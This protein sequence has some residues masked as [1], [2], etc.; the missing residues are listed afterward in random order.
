MNELLIEIGTEE[1]PA[2]PLLKEL[3]NIE[4]KW[5][6]ILE[7]YHLKSDFKFYYTP[8]RLVFFHENFPNKQ[9]DTFAQF[10]GAP[11]NIAYKD[12][13]LTPAGES[14][15]QKAQI[16]ENEL[17]FK[18]IKGKEVLYHQ[19]TIRGLSSQEILAPMINEFLKNLHFGKSMRWGAHTFEFIRAIRSIVCIFNDNLIDFESYGVKSAKKT[20]IHRS[21][22]YDLQEFNTIE[23]YFKLL[24]KNFIILDPLKRKERILKQFKTLEEQN[25]I[26]IAQDEELLAEVIAITEYPNALLGS[27][28]KTYLQIPHEVIIHSMRENQ[29]YFA[30]FNEKKLS[31]HFIVVSNAVCKDYSK[32]IH[33]NERVLHAR[34]SD[35]M[36]FYKNDIQNG[37]IP[38]KLNQI[39]YLEGLGTM[40]DKSLREIKI[41]EILCQML[42]NDQIANISTAIKYSKADLTTQ[43]VYEFTSLQGIMGSYYAQKMGLD[44]TICLAIK[45]QYLP[46]LEQAPLPSNEFSSIVALANK[47]DTLMGLFSIGKIPNGTKDPYAL[48]RAANGIIKIALNLNKEFDIQ[49]LLEKFAKYYK[50][51]DIQILKDF[52]FERLYTFYEVNT[53]FIKAVLS[54]KNTDLIHINQSVNALIK[55]SKKT[56]FNENFAT[57]K[58][59]ANIASNSSSFID[60]SLFIQEAET[61]LYE[62]FKEKI[63]ASSLEAKLENLFALKPFIDDFF[64][65]VMIND[66]NEKLKNNRQ[67]LVC[68]IYKEFLNIADLK[69]LSL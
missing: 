33:G 65:K 23:E 7:Q 64:D 63:H 69:E 67:A 61:K 2:I 57:F 20:F 32:I 18:Y 25:H 5:K 14:F 28:E 49:I 26:Q 9:E 4:K 37:L 40:Q 12:G 55:L 66:E 45:E 41:A 30:V 51:F 1:L 48:R 35:A 3:N 50:N 60:P 68:Q 21:I 27:F 43:M 8:R 44:E 17:E 31:N 54:S 15:L 19:K 42:K 46:D 10:I 52:I 58:R 36:F 13:V 6:N 11:K 39:I 22:A 53:S 59:L 24:E 29:R 62:A 56:N 47:F 38:E 16:S 34:L